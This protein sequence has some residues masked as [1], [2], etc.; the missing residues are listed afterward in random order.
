[1]KCAYSS[2]STY[3]PLLLGAPLYV[4]YNTFCIICSAGVFEKLHEAAY[5]NALSNSLYCPDHMVGHI[6]TNQ[7]W[8][9][10]GPVSQFDV[11]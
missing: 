7:V 10:S 2:F 8:R 3:S 4:L 5:K 1:M 9:T 6:S 11:G